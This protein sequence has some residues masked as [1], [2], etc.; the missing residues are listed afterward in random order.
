MARSPHCC[1][2]TPQCIFFPALSAVVD[3]GTEGRD[4]D[5]GEEA[6]ED[7]GGSGETGE[8]RA[9]AC[10]TPGGGRERE[11][12]EEGIEEGEGAPTGVAVLC[13]AWPIWACGAEQRWSDG[14]RERRRSR[15]SAGLAENG[16]PLYFLDSRDTQTINEILH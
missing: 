5:R 16:T 4:G 7:R 9:L 3:T 13:W 1:C 2:R 14:R 12:V 6:G 8:G 11:G 15:R 10:L